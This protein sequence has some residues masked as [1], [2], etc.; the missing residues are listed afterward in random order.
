MSKSD[1]D[2]AYEGD[3]IGGVEGVLSEYTGR[4]LTNITDIYHA[5][6]AFNTRFQTVINANLCHGIPDV[7]FDWFLLWDP[8]ALQSRRSGIT[9]SWSWS[10]WVGESFLHMWDWYNRSIIKIRKAQKKRTWI[11]WYQRKTHDSEE[12]VRVDSIKLPLGNSALAKQMTKRFP[13]ADCSQTVPTPR[14]LIDAPLYIEDTHNPNPGSGFLQFWTIS[15][16]FDL[17]KAPI[18]AD[19]D[20][21]EPWRRHGRSRASVFGADGWELG[22]IM[23]N[24]DWLDKNVPGRHEFIVLCEGRT[25]RA[26]QHNEIDKEPG[27]KYM[28]MLIEWHG[29]GQWAERVAIGAIEKDDIEHALEGG[30][31]WKEIVLG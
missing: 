30:P 3:D 23:I 10:G 31:V 4:S 28:V 15:V 21:P 20:D 14:K 13:F 29:G 26:K 22:T 17:D 16:T 5:I 24:P 8:Q 1:D 6:A 12:C 7:F 19:T 27:W 9:P 25:E 2:D 11:V 18:N